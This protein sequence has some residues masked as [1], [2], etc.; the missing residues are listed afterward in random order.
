M[1]LGAMKEFKKATGLDL[2]FTLLQYIEVYSQTVGDSA[3]S[4][5]RK[6]YEIA[7]LEVVSNVFYHLIREEDKSIPLAELQDAMF[8]VGWLP[9]DDDD[10]LSKPFPLVMV[11]LAYEVDSF[12]SDLPLKKK[13]DISEG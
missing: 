1:S 6:L 10:D 4:R 12:F 11:A 7:D 13:A 3:I 2:W 8:R 5:M 9:K